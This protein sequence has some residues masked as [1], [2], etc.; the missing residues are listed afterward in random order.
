MAGP[1]CMKFSGK[2]WSGSIQVN[3]SAGRRSICY[4]RSVAFASWQQ[5]AGFIVP[6]TTAC[7]I[8]GGLGGDHIHH[9][10]W[11]VVNIPQWWYVVNICGHILILSFE[12]MLQMG[13]MGQFSFNWPI[14][15]SPGSGYFPATCNNTSCTNV[16]V[17]AKKVVY[18]SRNTA[19]CKPAH[20]LS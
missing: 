15:P 8:C 5:G 6:C 13:V 12:M 1:I 4:H 19:F 17:Q 9:I 7:C 3:R 18:F 11:Y 14:F 10:W 16:F 2:V 20:R